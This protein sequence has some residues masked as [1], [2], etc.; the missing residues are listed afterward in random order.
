MSYIIGQ[1]CGIAATVASIIMPLYRHKWQML[2]NTALVNVLM[3]LNFVLI[4]EIGSAVC[5][6][7]VATVQS[8]VSLVHTQR[9]TKSGKTET[10]IFFLFYVGLGLF[11]MI[12]APG[13]VWQL[14]ARNLLELLPI[15]GSIMSM[16]FVLVRNE[17]KAR[18]F[19]LATCSIW[20]V[21][22]AVVGATT[23]FA[24]AFSVVTTVVAIC[25]YRP[26]KGAEIPEKN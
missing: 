19:L 7:A 10:A 26:R 9:G 18:W 24:E 23:F 15:V 14:S 22:T 2:L 8:L 11:G 20:S 17:Q 6:C 3:G 12:T 13:F 21:Y 1:A 4:G 5:L 25:K 16:T